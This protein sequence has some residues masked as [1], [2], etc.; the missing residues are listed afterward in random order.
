[1]QSSNWVT[2][3]GNFI[4]VIN[5]YIGFE[6]IK[7]FMVRLRELGEAYLCYGVDGRYKVSD[8][9]RCYGLELQPNKVRR[10]LNE[11]RKNGYVSIK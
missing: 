9:D 11:L 3:N 4:K 8:Y 10:K 2:V 7:F 6:S 5:T 1:M